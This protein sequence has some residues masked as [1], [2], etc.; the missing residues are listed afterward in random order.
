MFIYLKGRIAGYATAKKE[1]TDI[2][3]Y[4]KWRNEWYGFC[5]KIFF[6]NLNRF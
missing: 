6:K 2:F 5:E 3:E 4:K 1:E